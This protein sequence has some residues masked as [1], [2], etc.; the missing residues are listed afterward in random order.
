M[1][2]ATGR[3]K[4]EGGRRKAEL[5][6]QC[7]YRDGVAKSAFRMT[8]VTALLHVA[9]AC[10]GGHIQAATDFVEE[11]AGA[12][13]SASG[14]GNGSHLQQRVDVADAAGRLY[15]DVRRTVLPH[16]LQV[17]KRRAAGAVAGRGLHPI[18][19]DRGA[20]FTDLD[21][22]LVLEVAVLED[23]LQ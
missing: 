16:Q 8:L 1:E 18:D 17:F 6:R 20:D 7:N 14:G 19:A 9:V 12:A 22:L 10:D 3:R 11:F 23:D 13:A 15:L 2:W 4:W 21:L 5:R